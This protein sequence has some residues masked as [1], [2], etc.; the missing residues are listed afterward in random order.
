MLATSLGHDG[1]MKKTGLD[2]RIAALE[3]LDAVLRQKHPL[4]QAFDHSVVVAALPVRERAFARNLIAL[5]LR[6]LGQI[7]AL[8]SGCL[9]RPLGRKAG[10]AEMILRIGVCQLMFMDTA[11][12]AAISTAVDL[13]QQLGQG[14][15]KKLINAV[16][17]R[18]QRDG[19]KRLDKHDA[20]RLN[21]PDWLWSSWIAA[22]GEDAA[23]QIAAAHLC[24]PRLDLSCRRDPE[25]WAEKLGG[26]LL[27]WGT[28][29][30]EPGGNVRDLAGFDEGAWWVQ[31]AA[32]RLAVTLLGD[33]HG[34]NVIDLCA[35]PGGKTL[36]LASAGA[37]V[38]AVDR[39]QKRLGRVHENLQRLDLEA[40]V[41]AADALDWKPEKPADLIVLDAPCSATGTL[42]RHP[43]VAYL[44]TP[45]DV[46]KLA[47]LQSRL[48][49]AATGMLADNGTILFCTC[50][51]Q[52]EEGPAQIEQFLG[53]HRDF[54]LDPV[55]GA[56]IFVD[57]NPSGMFRS[58]PSD[59]AAEGGRDGFFAARLARG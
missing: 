47:D 34:K 54:R 41:I 59:M 49:D 9:D 57:D 56:E 44:K 12:H 22:Y 55:A 4:D 53:R 15:Y 58:L 26:V 5:T 42:R 32:A 10:R 3:I 35:A 28:V 23:R 1:A 50:S 30:L 16:L 7:D 14:P 2:T 13:A 27:P 45:D 24:E 37:K 52:D 40:S 39:S 11:D 20:A 43:D 46:S 31:D 17:R 6:R 29:R 36:Y 25:G 38:T 51:L 8:I 19:G 48:L 21:T 18:L 33:V